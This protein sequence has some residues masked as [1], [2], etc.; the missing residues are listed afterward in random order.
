MTSDDGERLN[1]LHRIVS[2][3]TVTVAVL[4][5][6]VVVLGMW[7]YDRT[8]YRDPVQAGGLVVMDR[9]LQRKGTAVIQ[10]AD[11]P[12]RAELMLGTGIVTAPTIVL[13]AKRDGAQIL[14]F[15]DLRGKV[16]ER[17]GLEANGN[18]MVKCFGPNGE[19]VGCAQ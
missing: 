14:E 16:R 13:S 19:A 8:V 1:R 4:A 12:Q 5:V 6:V 11:S 18:P 10:L 9:G 3:L 15:R 7:L 17:I 2:M